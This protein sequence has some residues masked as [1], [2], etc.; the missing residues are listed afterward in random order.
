MGSVG[1]EAPEFSSGATE[2]WL[3]PKKATPRPNR[4]GVTRIGA[5]Y[6]SPLASLTVR[7][8]LT[9]AVEF[10]TVEVLWLWKFGAV[11]ESL[12]TGNARGNRL[13]L[14][15]GRKEF[16]KHAAGCFEFWPTAYSSFREDGFAV[17]RGLLNKRRGR[18]L[19]ATFDLASFYDEIDPD[20]LVSDSFVSQLISSSSA[21][22]LA[23]N[24]AEYV[25]A[26]K[27]L[28]GAF[29]R[30]R[31]DAERLTG[32]TASRGIPIGCLSSKLISNLTLAS[33]D[34]HVT[35]NS[36]VRYYARYV[37][38][39]LLV[40]DVSRR[41]PTTA[42]GIA[43]A[44]LPIK[45]ASDGELLLDAGELGRHGCRLR[46]QTAKLKGYVLVGRRGLDFLDTVE[47]DVKLI[48][49]ERRAFLIPDGLGSE[50]PLTALFVGSDS[51]APVQVLREVDRLKVE[52]YAASVAIS[53]ASVGVELLD[54]AESAPWCRRQLLPLAGHITGPDQWLEFL[55]LSLRAVTVCIRARDTDTARL[56]L[57]RHSAHFATLGENRKP[58]PVTW[59]GRKLRWSVVT[60]NIRRW[61]EG[62]RLEEIL[63]SIPLD[64]IT[65]GDTRNFLRSALGRDLAIGDE[66]FGPVAVTNRVRLLRSADLR[67]SDRETDLQQLDS[68]SQFVSPPRWERLSKA[69]R[70]DAESSQ[71][72]SQVQQ[73]VNVCRGLNDYT[74]ADVSVPEILLMTRPPTQFDVA[75]RWAR[76]ERS[77][78]EL[79]A[80]TNAVRGTRYSE[81][82]VSQADESTIDI[83]TLDSFL[84]G[85]PQDA[86]L[87]L[88][89]LA[90][91]DEWF[92]SAAKGNPV[93]T[94]RRMASIS[95]IVNDAIRLRKKRKMPTVL[96]LPELSL[97][98]RLL[99]PLAHRLI[100]EDVTLIAGLEYTKAGAYVINQAIGVFAPGFRIAFVCWWPKS[101]PARV[102]NRELLKLGAQFR[103]HSVNPKV[104]STD[105]GSISTLICSELLDVQ[106]RAQ[107]LGRIDLLVV[108]SWNK[109]T[110]TF[111]HT[112]QTTANDLHAY[113]AVAN[114]AQFSD[115]RVQVPS[116]ERHERDACRLISRSDDETISV[117]ISSDALRQFQLASLANPAA[118]L[119]GF[120]PLPPGY[121]FNR[122]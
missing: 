59:N 107:L 106:T 91:K 57:R 102:E 14:V 119:K 52:R 86:L 99:R 63:S 46:L 72:W 117:I 20:F 85:G 84:R 22:R 15:E 67:T 51:D 38:D 49:S 21:K 74:Y 70:R 7:S 24:K 50:S 78:N 4:S 6:E 120:K 79:V 97:P 65:S 75:C 92:V 104:V 62:R 69:I 26:T 88:G 43:R 23:F 10:A 76:S 18:C 47:R 19:V 103:V 48:A 39:I 12:L 68:E 40:A 112:V 27:S 96:I 113:V 95:R 114:N 116:D 60:D 30:Y 108:P 110:A 33:L 94:R 41:T 45:S 25:R 115:C 5:Q 77:V 55:E 36:D 17:A 82:S 118:K 54:R 11:L 61:Y 32:I 9:P 13:K 16:H 71:R 34:Q 53:K 56:I 90:T 111:D 89:N 8:H 83:R 37:D 93:V 105:F 58:P 109:D 28:L 73:F 44:F 64:V 1:A 98:P 121:K 122:R 2:V 29:G 81:A 87:V 31:S 66:T 42:R 101:L 35:R 3:V 100:G 80:V